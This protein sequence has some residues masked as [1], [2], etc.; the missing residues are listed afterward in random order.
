MNFEFDTLKCCRLLIKKGFQTNKAR[1]VV[2]VLSSTDI[3]N[4]STNLEVHDMTAS[5]VDD[6]FEKYDKRVAKQNEAYEKQLEKRLESD[7]LWHENNRK[8]LRSAFRWLATTIIT[9]FVA[10]AGYIAALIHLT[11]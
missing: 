8:E 5:A 9:A 6:Y 3:R 7:R 2:D 1:A 10:F 11:H 4:L